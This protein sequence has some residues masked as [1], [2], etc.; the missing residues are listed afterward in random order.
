VV[1]VVHLPQRVLLVVAAAAAAAAMGV[2]VRAA[3]AGVR[4]VR[5]RGVSWRWWNIMWG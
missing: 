1:W 2:V 4:V 3:V 5:R